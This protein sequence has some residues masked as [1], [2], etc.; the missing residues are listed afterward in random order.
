MD[1]ARTS[2]TAAAHLDCPAVI[3]DIAL[4][5]LC[6]LLSIWRHAV[7]VQGMTCVVHTVR[8]VGAVIR[9]CT[10]SNMHSV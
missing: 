1:A 4:L 10:V 6:V 7:N 5:Q 3:P 8:C 2:L 9:A